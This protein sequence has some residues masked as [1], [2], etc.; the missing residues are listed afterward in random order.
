VIPLAVGLGLFQVGEFAFVLGRVGV[1]TKSI[2]SELFSLILTTAIITMILTP[3]LSGLTAPLYAV[4]RRWFKHEP[5]QTVN[6]PEEELRN[7]VII[8]GAGRVGAYV[9]HVLKNLNVPFVVIEYDSRQVNRLKE[10]GIPLVYGD[11]SQPIVLN[12]ARIEQAKLLI[13]TTP[14]AIV[15]KTIVEKSRQVNP[16]LKI[17]ARAENSDQIQIL[18]KLGVN[19]VIQPEFEAGL[20]VTRQALLSLNIAASDIKRFTDQVRQESYAPL[21]VDNPE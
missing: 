9:A 11:A 10:T 12:A 8:A 5:L 7:H 4:R 6:L 21:S 20:E 1:H 14:A 13:I 17:V 18:H 16:T 3:F 19:E 15:T 2:S